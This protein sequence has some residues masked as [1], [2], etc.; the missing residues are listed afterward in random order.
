[1]TTQTPEA[2]QTDIAAPSARPVAL[3]VVTWVAQVVAAVILGQTLFFKFTGAPETVALFDVLGVEPWGRYA[4][5][6]AELIAVVLLLIPRTAW[7]GG[8]FSVAVISGAIMAHLTRLGISIDPAALGNQDLEAL[9]G[10]SLFVMA[11]VVFAAG[12][13]VA[14]VRRAEIPVVGAMLA[15]RSGSRTSPS[16]APA[17]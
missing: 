16:T 4:T 11:V 1:M 6:F 13:T 9:A 15:P 12:L 3:T 5:A 2:G 10:T 7:A 14:A 8:L 17:A